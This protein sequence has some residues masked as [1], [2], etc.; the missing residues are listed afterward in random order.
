MREMMLAAMEAGIDPGLGGCQ[1]RLLRKR[2][3]CPLKPSQARLFGIRKTVGRDDAPTA[4]FMEEAH[5][6]HRSHRAAPNVDSW[7][8]ISTFNLHD[9]CL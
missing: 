8:I 2:E 6:T 5:V 4:F 3:A 1:G 9:Q 7:A